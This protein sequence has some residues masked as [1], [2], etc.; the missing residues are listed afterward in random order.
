MAS[1]APQKRVQMLDCEKWRCRFVG[2]VCLHLAVLLRPHQ[3][4]PKVDLV[5]L[6]SS[7]LKSDNRHSQSVEC[8]EDESEQVFAGQPFGAE[9]PLLEEAFS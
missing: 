2:F 3:D 7:C 1:D 5:L 6:M 9:V 4:I 8:W